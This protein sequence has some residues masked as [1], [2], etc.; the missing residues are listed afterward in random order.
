M[1]PAPRVKHQ[2]NKIVNVP[3]ILGWG[4]IAGGVLMSIGIKCLNS[5]QIFILYALTCLGIVLVLIKSA[6]KT[7]ANFKVGNIS[8]S[9][10]GGLAFFF[11][12]IYTNPIG[13]FKNNDCNPTVST[14]VFVRGADGPQ[15]MILRKK[16]HVIM[17]LKGERRKADIN[18]N[19]VAYF[20]NLHVGDSVTLQVDFSEPYK[21][22]NP[23]SMY[24]INSNGSIYMQVTLQGINQVKGRIIYHDA[25]LQDVIVSIDMLSDTTDESGRY[26]INIPEQQQRQ[27]Y[28]VWFNKQ[29][30][31]MKS[32]TAYPQTG[33]DLNIVM[34]KQ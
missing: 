13:T 27:H 34:E 22:I 16:G 21:S 26:R 20:Q 25:P 15:D 31:K 33:E 29:G 5:S 14:S 19:G 2:H 8:F 24:V 23:D 10:S 1:L 17:D 3:R 18:E 32:A 12:L 7:T 28:E 9:L 6:N 30:F 4:C 11:I